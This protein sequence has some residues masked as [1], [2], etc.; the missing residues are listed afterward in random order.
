MKKITYSFPFVIAISL[1]IQGLGLVRSLILAKDFGAN[2][3]LDAFYL[4]NVF[5]ISVFA[6]VGSAITTIVIPELNSKIDFK[7]KKLYIEK[8]LTFIRLFSL[9]LSLIL[10]IIIILGKNLIV[11]RF[12]EQIKILFIILT[13][14]LLISQQFRIQASFSVS[15]LQNEGHYITP[16][17]LDI[18]PVGIPVIYLVLADPVDIKVLTILTAIAYILETIIFNYIQW[19]LNSK[20]VFR[21]RLGL[22]DNVKKMLLNTLPI[23]LSS[24]VF[25]IQVLASNYFAGFFGHGYITLLSNTKQIMGIFQSLFIMREYIEIN[26]YNN[27]GL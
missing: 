20:F 26:F 9:I 27:S 23:L 7:L 3:M 22:D 1:I 19:K 18:I 5:T 6:V 8:Y 16:R 15:L 21:L 24:T 14:I 13:A 4:A 25:Q 10:L 17:L 2:S 12:D 11:P